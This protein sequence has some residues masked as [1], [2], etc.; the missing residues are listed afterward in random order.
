MDNDKSEIEKMEEQEQKRLEA[1]ENKKNLEMNR[2][3]TRKV[4]HEKLVSRT[5]AKAY[6]RD[7]KPSAFVFLK[8]ICFIRDD[9]KEE[10]MHQDVI[11]WLFTQA[12]VFVKQIENFDRY[13]NTFLAKHIDEASVTHIQHVNDHIQRI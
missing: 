7:I 2:R 8:D 1:Y 11:P 13:P 4:A 9:F 5:I 3:N 12:E 10:T 6:L